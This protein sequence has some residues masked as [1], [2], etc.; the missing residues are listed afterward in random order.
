MTP[1]SP[2]KDDGSYCQGELTYFGMFQDENKNVPRQ[3]E[4][5]RK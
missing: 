5:S 1:L 4:L 2:G 3:S